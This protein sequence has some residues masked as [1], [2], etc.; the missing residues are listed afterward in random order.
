MSL[1]ALLLVAAFP[2]F[3]DN[4]TQDDLIIAVNNSR[5]ATVQDYLLRGG[6][7]DAADRDG[8]SLLMLAARAK[9]ARMIDLLLR[10]RA[11][12]HGT[13]LRGETAL[14]HAAWSRCEPCVELLLQRGV[15]TDPPGSEWTALHY[16]AHQGD[17]RIVARLLFAGAEPNAR[18][19]NGT[20]PLMMGAMS[21]VADVARA[22]L[23]GGADPALRNA[24][25]DRA[26]DLALARRHTDYAAVLRGEEP[27][28]LFERVIERVRPGTRPPEGAD[29]P[30]SAQ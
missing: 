18:S 29:T 21:G 22:L 6:D 7:A 4:F 3:G 2:W 23:K 16:S 10:A 17:A 1:S 20:T 24:N 28:S 15:R 12:P 9:D 11:K 26:E 30:V 13:N 14:M 19:R 5:H 27:R 8:N 25:Q